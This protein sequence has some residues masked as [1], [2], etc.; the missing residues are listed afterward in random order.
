MPNHKILYALALCL[1]PGCSGGSKVCQP[2][3]ESTDY[4]VRFDRLSGDC[5][6]EDVLEF[7][8]GA[9][10]VP[11]GCFAERNEPGC[12]L[13]LRFRC[14]ADAD[15][16]ESLHMSLELWADA[17]GTLFTGT[18]DETYVNEDGTEACRQRSSVS[19][20]AEAAR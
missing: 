11:P 3:L 18:A 7:V 10:V 8:G 19:W 9:P 17:D 13:S 1:L 15:T 6:A 16:G 4:L 20:S 12:E 14:P 2:P 5:Y